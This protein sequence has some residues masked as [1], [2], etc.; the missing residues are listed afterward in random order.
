MIHKQSG[1]GEAVGHMEQV[2]VAAGCQG[3]LDPLLNQSVPYNRHMQPC[4]HIL[5]A[6]TYTK[7]A[8]HSDS[9]S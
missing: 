5:Q 7:H 8:C 1:K 6:F 9:T 2:A 3:L 4:I